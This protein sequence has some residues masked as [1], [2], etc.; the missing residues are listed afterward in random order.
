MAS[1]YWRKRGT[2]MS[3]FLIYGSCIIILAFAALYWL[4]RLPRMFGA[5]PRTEEYIPPRLTAGDLRVTWRAAEREAGIYEPDPAGS[6]YWVLAPEFRGTGRPEYWP[7][8]LPPSA[9]IQPG[10]PTLDLLES[11]PRPRP[12]PP[13][14]PR[15]NPSDSSWAYQSLPNKATPRS[16]AHSNWSDKKAAEIVTAIEESL[17][18]QT[19]AVARLDESWQRFYKEL[20]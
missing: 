12:L 3:E 17:V 13:P 15:R 20:W 6:D 11:R 18:R 7:G 9:A 16:I 14:R 10:E 1:H 2:C 8:A 4:D 5:P 19:H